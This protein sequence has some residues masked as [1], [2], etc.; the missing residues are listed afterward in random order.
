MTDSSSARQLAAKQ[1][2]GKVRHLDGKIF[3]IQQHVLQGDVHLQQLPTVWNV[4]D[5]CTKALNQKRVKLLL[6][7]LNVCDDGG[8]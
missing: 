4:S 1:G 8:F 6:H 7:E 2:V 3:W 5:L